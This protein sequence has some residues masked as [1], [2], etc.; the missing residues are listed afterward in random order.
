[1]QEICIYLKLIILLY[2]DDT[3]IFS[4]S[5]DSLQYALN[6]FNEYCDKWRLT[7]NAA[8]TKII[9]FNS[10]GRPKPT[11]KF[12]LK[13]AD[14]EIINEYKYLGIYFSQSGAFV[15]A[16]KHIAEQANKAVFSFIKNIKR[17]SLL[18]F[19]IQ[20]DLF[21]KTIKP[22]LLYGYEIWGV[23]N[24]DVIERVQ[25][26]YF[27]QIFGLKKVN[28]FIYVVRRTWRYAPRSWYSYGH[29]FTLVEINWK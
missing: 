6:T 9:I 7:V 1:M 22:I 5:E 29:N 27:K 10:R 26:N 25:L 11:T 20:I 13:G 15:S 24:N 28:T 17:L 12:T 16:K 4:D 21:E 3:V 14:I 19:D 18:P 23:G 8:K 2:A